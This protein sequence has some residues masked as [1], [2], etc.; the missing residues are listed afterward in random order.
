MSWREPADSCARFADLLDQLGVTHVVAG[1]LAALRYRAEPRLTTDVD[2]IVRLVPD[3]ADA[4]YG[5]PVR[6]S[7]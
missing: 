7:I 6:V 3:L 4:L 5:V 1:A 2:F